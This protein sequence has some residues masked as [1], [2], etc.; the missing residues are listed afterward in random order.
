MRGQAAKNGDAAAMQALLDQHSGTM[1][2]DGVITTGNQT[3]KWGTEACHT[4]CRMHNGC[5]MH[6]VYCIHMICVLPTAVAHP[7]RLHT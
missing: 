5:R 1:K 7:R 4:G 3:A 2:V 6:T